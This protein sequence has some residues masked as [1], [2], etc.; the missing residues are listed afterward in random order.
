V[1][2]EAVNR[3]SYYATTGT[4][5]RDLISLLHPPYTLW[6]LAYVAM[7][8]AVAPE[9]NWVNLAGTL[10]AF[11][12]GLGITAH[13]LDELH[14]RPL[15]TGL[16]RRS[17]VALALLGLVGAATLAV[18]GAFLISPWVLAWAAAGF[19]LAIGYPL[20]KPGWLHTYWGFALAWGGFPV[21]VGYWAQAET[22]SA[23]AVLL[24]G[25]A[26]VISATQ[27]SL[28]TPARYVRRRTEGAS[29]SFEPREDHEEWDRGRLLDTWERPL[30]LLGWSMTLLA[31][32]LLARHF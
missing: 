26:A 1:G 22:L 3:P 7:G 14:D 17:L 29:A 9:V 32:A 11:F 16:S 21:L 31:L 12:F 19:A 8:A 20:E 10:L 23:P 2:P 30:R 18:A 5:G 25:F 27:R 6:H 13:A 15:K 4:P 24:A 28:S